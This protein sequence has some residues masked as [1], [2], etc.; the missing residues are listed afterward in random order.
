MP[1]VS[2]VLLIPNEL[3][4]IGLIVAQGD[5]VL[6]E[7]GTTFEI[8]AASDGRSNSTYEL[9]QNLVSEFP[10]VLHV[11]THPYNQC[12]TRVNWHSDLPG[13]QGRSLSQRNHSRRCLFSCR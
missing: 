4:A 1:K 10:H 13:P 2:A 6:S 3:D 12:A 8:I 7:Q 11:V 9:S 5:H